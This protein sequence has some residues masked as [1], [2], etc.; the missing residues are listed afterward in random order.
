MVSS[1]STFTFTDL[2]PYDWVFWLLVIIL[3]FFL[4]WLFFGGGDYEFVGLDPFKIGV[5]SRKY[6]TDEDY[7]EIKRSNAAANRITI[8]N[9]TSPSSDPSDERD[10]EIHSEKTLEERTLDERT[11]ERTEETVVCKKN[12]YTPENQRRALGKYKCHKNNKLSKGEQLCKDVIEDIY[13]L[14]FYCVRPSFL[15]N[16]ETGRNLELDLYNDQ[17]KIAVEYN[18]IGHYK[19]PNPFHRTKEEFI[20]QI[21]RDKFKVDMC[22]VNDVYLISVPYTIPLNYSAIKDYIL[23]RL[24]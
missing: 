4:L 13:Q 23:E 15:K 3:I 14:P 20:N 5:D 17:V 16:P 11:E 22:D 1:G 24:P 7:E 10:P 8:K 18:G 21:R 12:I 6:I 9:F 2:F 19:Y